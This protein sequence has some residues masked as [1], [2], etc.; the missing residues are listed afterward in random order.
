MMTESRDVRDPAGESGSLDQSRPEDVS[1]YVA[2]S[3]PPAECKPAPRPPTGCESKEEPS[4]ADRA[5]TSCV[6]HSCGH[7]CYR[8]PHYDTCYGTCE[9]NIS[10]SCVCACN[11]VHDVF[12]TRNIQ[13]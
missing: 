2:Q 6:K 9:L 8:N 11:T 12:L 4:E 5:L 7:Y 3:R 13:K 10:G 1:G